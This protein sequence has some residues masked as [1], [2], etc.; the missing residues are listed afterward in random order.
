MSF[1]YD[2]IY[3]IEPLPSLFERLQSADPHE[4][5]EVLMQRCV[6]RNREGG[7][8]DWRPPD[9]EEAA[10]LLFLASLQQYTP[11][12]DPMEFIALFGENRISAELFDRW[13][14]MERFV[15]DDE[16]QSLEKFLGSREVATTSTDRPIVARWLQELRT[17]HSR[18]VSTL[19]LICEK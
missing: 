10:K 13:F 3:L 2:A 11:L 15:F 7:N 12:G 19:G 14:R 17:K 4:L 16:L 5:S 1:N 9:S 8:S 6:F 18:H